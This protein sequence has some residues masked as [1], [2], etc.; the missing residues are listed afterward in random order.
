[1]V[2]PINYLEA[3]PQIDIGKSFIE[4]LKFGSSIG[5]IKQNQ[6]EAQ[7]KE[8]R[9]QSFRGE[10]EKAFQQANPD[11]WMQLK[12][13]YPEYEKV[14]SPVWEQLDEKQRKAEISQYL[15][16][17]SALNAGNKEVA[18]KYVQRLIDANASA[19]KD[20][21]QFEDIASQIDDDINIARDTLVNTTAMVLPLKDFAEAQKKLSE[22]KRAEAMAPI[23]MRKESAEVISKE[24][25]NKFKPEKL[26]ADLGLTKAQTEQAKAA[27]AASRA[28]AAKSGAEAARAQAEARQMGAGVI[29]LDK[30]PEA[31][32]KFRKEY[33]DQTKGYQEVKSAYQ[34]IL[35]SEDSAVGDLSLIFGYMKMLDP[36]SVVREGEFA[37]AQNAAGVPDRVMNLY[38]RA[39][40]GQRLDP[41]Q[42]QSFK[43]QAAKLYKTAATQEET[44]RN[45][46]GRIATGYG[47]KTQNIFYAPTE[48][49]PAAPA[50]AQK[51][52]PTPAAPQPAQNRIDQLLKQYGA[53]Q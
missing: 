43:G 47:L 46:I 3:V 29:P 2:Q 49:T 1:M 35:A 32:A 14:I 25:E 18:K 40:S 8:Q 41:S 19:G 39:V 52:A 34:R 37:T 5:Q 31:E 17:Q 23:T 16:L 53:P 22:T 44:V 13:K 27:V 24:I 7:Q 28:A 9:L 15:P 21:K 42:R 33:S 6:Q 11:V 26:A 10:V 48:V 45:G 20:T 30:R 12:T 50:A 51:A 36:G 4:G 38:N